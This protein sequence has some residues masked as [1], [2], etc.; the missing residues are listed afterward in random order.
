M[1]KKQQIEQLRE[2]VKNLE[3]LVRNYHEGS[4]LAIHCVED[5]QTAILLTVKHN[6]VHID[7]P[8]GDVIHLD[9]ARTKVL[10]DWLSAHEEEL[11]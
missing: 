9:K 7:C 1:T 3:A 2:R 10:I 8:D 6:Q 4:A 11:E 5:Y